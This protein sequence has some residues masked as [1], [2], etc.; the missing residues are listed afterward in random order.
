MRAAVAGHL[1]CPPQAVK[2]DRDANGEPRLRAPGSD[3]HLS[4]SGRDDFVLVAIAREPVGVDLEP[5]GHPFEPPWNVLH[6]EEQAHLR[7][8]SDFPSRHLAFLRIWTAKEAAVKA[9]GAGLRREPESFAIR[10]SEPDSFEVRGLETPLRLRR[11]GMVEDS[12][13]GRF[14]WACA[15]V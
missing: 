10:L 4:L 8:I 7:A 5:V 6:G 12:D 14:L 9:L 13:Q 3:R 11:S 2:I 1:R 15:L